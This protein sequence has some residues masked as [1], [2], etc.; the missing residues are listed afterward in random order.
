MTSQPAEVPPA[1]ARP[2]CAVSPPAAGSERI[3]TASQ[4]DSLSEGQPEQA[5]PSPQQVLTLWRRCQTILDDSTPAQRLHNVFEASAAKANTGWWAQATCKNT[6]KS[7]TS[8]PSSNT[9]S[10][11]RIQ[12]RI[13]ESLEQSPARVLKLQQKSYCHHQVQRALSHLDRWAA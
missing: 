7:T 3:S 8:T 1:L 4:N 11:V 2:F 5:R 9:R 12:N 6:R 13:V 10:R